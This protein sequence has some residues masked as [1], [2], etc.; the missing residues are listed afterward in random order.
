[1]QV[2][3]NFRIEDL[4]SFFYTEFLQ[5]YSLCYTTNMLGETQYRKI[6]W[7]LQLIFNDLKYTICVKI[8]LFLFAMI[9]IELLKSSP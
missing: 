2:P 4:S 5:A 8:I 9:W 1:M 7:D 6:N 3:T